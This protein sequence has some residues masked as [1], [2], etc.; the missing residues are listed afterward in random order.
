MYGELRDHDPSKQMKVFE[1]LFTIKINNSVNSVRRAESC[2]GEHGTS[3]EM[4]VL[5]RLLNWAVLGGARPSHMS[6]T[7]G[8]AA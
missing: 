8:K 2:L 6:E 1:R 4:R 5:E 3:I 7:S